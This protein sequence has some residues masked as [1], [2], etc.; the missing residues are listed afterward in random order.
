M[1][2]DGWMDWAF[3]VLLAAAIVLICVAPAGGGS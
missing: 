1:T 3:R 2:D